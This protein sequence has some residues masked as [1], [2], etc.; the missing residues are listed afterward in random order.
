MND[1][2]DWFL[3][4]GQGPSFLLDFDD[5]L[6]DGL[7]TLRRLLPEEVESG[8]EWLERFSSNSPPPRLVVYRVR[9]GRP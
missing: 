5:V 8:R 2:L 4:L 6:G 3:D 7:E 1:D 9:E